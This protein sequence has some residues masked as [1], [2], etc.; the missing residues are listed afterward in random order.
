MNMKKSALSVIA[1][2]MFTVLVYAGSPLTPANVEWNKVFIRLSDY[3]L[4]GQSKQLPLSYAY[5]ALVPVIDS[6][7]VEIHYSKHH[8]AYTKNLNDGTV[9]ADYKAKP[10]FQMFDEMEKY[11]VLVRNNGGG[12]YNHLLYWMIM[13][14]Q[15]KSGQL[16]ARLLKAINESFGSLDKFKTA[17]GDAGKK[18]FG[19]GWA[20][21]SVGAD[22][23]L[24]VSS[25]PNQDNPLMSISEKRGIP[26]F[27]IDVWE[28]AYYLQYQNRR[29]DY[30]DAFWGIV[31]WQEVDRRYDEALKALKQ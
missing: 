2:T 22:G 23:K 26:I 19:S 3:K 7:T 15:A 9:N 10:L 17:F 30:V 13:T 12:Y 14:S 20:W 31:N 4:T 25:T 16:G 6:R 5:D 18:Q 11:P 1:V 24:F 27:L 29:A 21:L 8:A 28:H